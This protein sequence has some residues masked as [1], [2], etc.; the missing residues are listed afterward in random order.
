MNRVIYHPEHPENLPLIVFLHGAG[1]RGTNWTHLLRLA[2][3]KLLEEGLEIPAVVLCPQC[4][5]HLVWDNVVE[6]C[7]AEIDRV[8]QQY[9]ID[10]DRITVTGASMG[11]IGTW[12]MGLT[13]PN[14]FAAIAPVAGNCSMT[15]RSSNLLSTPVLAH[16]GDLDADVLLS[17]EKEMIKAVEDVGGQAELVILQGFAHNDGIEYA[18]AHG[19][20]LEWL[21]NRKKDRSVQIREHLSELF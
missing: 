6:E 16:H 20:V 21:L 15:W 11:G 18:Y 17:S 12:M 10:T 4:P 14:D 8:V 5:A 9:A 19:N 7:K 3:P 1:E 13:Y 2:L